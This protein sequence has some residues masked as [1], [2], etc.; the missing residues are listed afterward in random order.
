MWIEKVVDLVQPPAVPIFDDRLDEKGLNQAQTEFGLS[1]PQDALR[2]SR[3]YGL[4][5]FQCW[6]YWLTVTN[7]LDRSAWKGLEVGRESL[8]ERDLSWI[9]DVIESLPGGAE[10]ERFA[11]HPARGGLVPFATD[12]MGNAVLWTNTDRSADLWN[13]V[14]MLHGGIPGQGDNCFFELP[15]SAGEF[16]VRLLSGW[17]PCGV[18]NYLCSPARLPVRFVQKS[19]R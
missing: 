1:L 6:G 8:V 9:Q 19:G 16:L 10:K 2:L 4:G 11:R 17:N 15:M 3:L 5:R 18:Y 13:V 7:F 12:D 14:V